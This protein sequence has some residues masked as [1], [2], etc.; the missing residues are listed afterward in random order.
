MKRE[1]AANIVQHIVEDDVTQYFVISALGSKMWT[2]LKTFS[3]ITIIEARTMSR[4]SS[5]KFIHPFISKWNRQDNSKCANCTWERRCCWFS[6]WINL[7]DILQLSVCPYQLLFSF[8]LCMAFAY[9]TFATEK[10]DGLKLV[11]GR[12][13]GNF[14]QI[15]FQMQK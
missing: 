11:V 12:C 8:H 15:F 6:L 7:R 13:G 4:R 10:K 2:P 14:T 9:L 3:S 1:R 5:I